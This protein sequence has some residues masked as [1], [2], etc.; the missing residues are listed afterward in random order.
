MIFNSTVVFGHGLAKP[1]GFLICFLGIAAR[2]SEKKSKAVRR[3]HERHG[4]FS[5][6]V[7]VSTA[8]GAESSPRLPEV[9][10]V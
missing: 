3:I 9:V 8:N 10:I 1:A 4:L 2:P 6:T 7:M 5:G